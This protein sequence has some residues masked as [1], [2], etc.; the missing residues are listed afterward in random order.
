M[1]MH[2]SLSGLHQPLVPLPLTRTKIF[3]K[4]Q[5]LQAKLNKLMLPLGT[6]ITFIRT[7]IM[8]QRW[9]AQTLIGIKFKLLEQSPKETADGG[10]M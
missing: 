2:Q 6:A 8:S 3:A 9:V 4:T 5:K 10:S 7:L 1:R